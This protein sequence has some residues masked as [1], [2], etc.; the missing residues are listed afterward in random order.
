MKAKTMGMKRWVAAAAAVVAGVLLAGCAS[1][2][3]MADAPQVVQAPDGAQVIT[4]ASARLICEQVR[5]PVLTARWSSQRPSVVVLSIGLPYQRAEVTSA[6]F[7]FGASRVVRLRVKS[8]EA[9][10]ASDAPVTAFDVPVSLIDQLAYT[11]S[12][13]VRVMTADGGAVQETVSTGDERSDAVDAMR[14]FLRAVDGAT[15]T[16]PDARGGG[17]G[18][19]DLLK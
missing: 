19:F 16:P 18:L 7:H 1:Q 13:W 2:T 6:D 3:P 9:P 4:S 14:R 15:G 17:G 12:G 11:P 10:Q 5:C 8:D